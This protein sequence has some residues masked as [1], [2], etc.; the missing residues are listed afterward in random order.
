MNSSIVIMEE[1][2]KDRYKQLNERIMNMDKK[3]LTWMKNTNIEVKKPENMWI[4][5]KAKQW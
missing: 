1:E 5:I 2:E 3:T 4:R